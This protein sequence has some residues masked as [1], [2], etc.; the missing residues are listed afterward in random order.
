MSN[1]TNNPYDNKYLSSADAVRMLCARLPDHPVKYGLGK[2]AIGLGAGVIGLAAVAG[3]VSSA[4]S[5][6]H[7][8]SKL[9]EVATIA[10]G[11]AGGIAAARYTIDG[12]MSMAKP[13]SEH[14]HSDLYFH[15]GGYTCNPG[16]ADRLFGTYV[17]PIDSVPDLMDIRGMVFI[18]RAEINR[19]ILI[20]RDGSEINDPSGQDIEDVELPY[21]L[22]LSMEI[23]RQPFFAHQE[24]KKC[25]YARALLELIGHGHEKFFI[26]GDTIPDTTNVTIRHIGPAFYERR[27]KCSIEVT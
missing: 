3:I 8:G 27:M 11:L 2:V 24:I 20:K 6:V 9:E 18:N 22:T 21:K 25:E 23:N 12:L 26:T 19:I 17:T 1:S 16:Q 15:N 13:L 7:I 4:L 14:E 5:K 10:V